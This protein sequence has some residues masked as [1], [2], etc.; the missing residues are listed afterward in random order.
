MGEESKRFLHERCTGWL[1]AFSY[2]AGIFGLALLPPSVGNDIFSRYILY[3]S[4]DIPYPLAKHSSGDPLYD[5]A[6]FTLGVAGAVTFGL[7]ISLATQF[8]S[9]AWRKRDMESWNM[10]AFPLFSW[11]IVDSVYSVA[12]GFYPNAILNS[13]LL[14]A[15]GVPLLLCRSTFAYVGEVGEKE[16]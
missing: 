1:K 14:A 12:S 13:V 10:V 7:S 8:H 6:G 16:E 2:G 4:R 5:Y 9:K 15:I 11:Y 3:E